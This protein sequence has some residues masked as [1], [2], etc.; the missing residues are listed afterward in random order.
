MRESKLVQPNTTKSITQNDNKDFILRMVCL[1]FSGGMLIV[2][3]LFITL[4]FIYNAFDSSLTTTLAGPSFPAI[5][6]GLLF[7]SLPFIMHFFC[8]KFLGIYII[9]PYIAFIF[10]SHFMGTVLDVYD[11]RFIPGMLSS[12]WW[13]KVMHTIFGY[14][15]ALIGL[16]F[17]CHIARIEKLNA[18]T[19]LFFCI[20]ISA[21]TTVVW[22]ICE[23][24]SDTWLGESCQGDRIFLRDAF[25]NF[26]LDSAGK[27][28]SI[29]TVNDTM[30]DIIVH[31]IGTA[32]FAI[33]YI[34][35]ATTK[36]SLFLTGMKKEFS[37]NC[38]VKEKVKTSVSSNE[39][40]QC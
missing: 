9:I 11:I 15:A 25:G 6:L 19:I 39:C 3:L 7:W 27:P 29:I 30:G 8:K 10:L 4:M 18:L 34:I 32:I 35:H 13:D 17:L 28:I 5:S 37:K 33:Q 1:V 16:F 40:N 2:H 20:G 24:C 21:L 31:M 23:F 36:K 22:E 26:I 14:L 38:F 12:N